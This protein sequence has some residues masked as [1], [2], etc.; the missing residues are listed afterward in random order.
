MRFLGKSYICGG[1]RYLKLSSCSVVVPVAVQDSGAE[2]NP[3]P[4]Y[5]RLVGE[6]VLPVPE[7]V[8]LSAFQSSDSLARLVMAH[9]LNAAAGSPYRPFSSGVF[10]FAESL[11]L[12][13]DYVL[14]DYEAPKGSVRTMYQAVQFSAPGIVEVVSSPSPFPVRKGL[15]PFLSYQETVSDCPKDF[16]AYGDPAD[17][18]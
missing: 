8:D 15:F 9:V 7:D 10:S 4:H 3:L 16:W 5:F 11:F 14:S 6:V 17:R 12:A 1:M 2:A 13:G 18:R